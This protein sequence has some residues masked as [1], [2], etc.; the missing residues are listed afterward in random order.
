M[1]TFIPNITDIFPEPP[2]FT[3]NFGFL[4]NMLRRKQ[5]LYEQGFSQLANQYRNITRSLTNPY[6][7]KIRDEYLKQAQSSLKSISTLDLSQ[8]QNVENASKIFEPFYKNKSVLADMALTAH[9][10]QQES[11][12]E[13]YR[14]REGGKEYSDD[15]INLVRLQ[16]AKFAKDNPSNYGMYLNSKEYYTPYYNYSDEYLKAIEKFKPSSIVTEKLDGFYKI[17]TTDKSWYQQELNEYLDKVLSDKAKNQMRI[18]STVRLGSL[19]TEQ[20]GRIYSDNLKPTVKTI[21]QKVED[22]ELYTRKEKDPSKLRDYTSSLEYYKNKLTELNSIINAV[23]SNDFSYIE[24]NK[25]K[26]AFDLYYHQKIKDMS[27]AFAHKDIEVD[28]DT[29]TVALEMWKEQQANWR[30]LLT[31]KREREKEGKKEEEKGVPVRVPGVEVENL[32]KIESDIETAQSYLEATKDYLKS[33]ISNTIYMGKK[34]ASEINE[35]DFKRFLELKTIIDPNTGVRTI[36]DDV[37]PSEKKLLFNFLNAGAN[38]STQQKKKTTIDAD[39]E[40]Y[41]RSVLGEKDYN[42]AKEYYSRS[43]DISDKS[44]LK[45]PTINPLGYSND[46]TYVKNKVE[47]KIKIDTFDDF[48]KS[49]GYTSKELRNVLDS[50]VKNINN[51]KSNPKFYN[52][53]INRVGIALTEKSKGYQNIITVLGSAGID[54]KKITGVT[55][56]NTA[57]GGDVMIGLQTEGKESID[58][59]TAKEKLTSLGYNDISI[60]GNKLYIKG[61][62]SKMNPGASN[63]YSIVHPNHVTAVEYLETSFVTPGTNRTAEITFADRENNPYV[64]NIKKSGGVGADDA[65]YYLT[66]PNGRPLTDGPYPNIIEA[67]TMAAKIF[68]LPKDQILTLYSNK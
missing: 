39:A 41:A 2:L 12:A 60:L 9:W 36:K 15:N 47:E 61:A 25:Q 55:K 28:I 8:N 13:S 34:P 45:K 5:A 37:S 40:V 50:Y 53:S 31:D 20:L 54:S 17:K 23:E 57:S 29:N 30:A 21:Q 68:N 16:K 56:I 59:I 32:S 33:H 3:P 14:L 44:R 52:T 64:I 46:N 49:K 19:P 4:D 62:Y 26:L 1:A 65:M 42:I 48:A 11:I 51:F 22:L 66:L 24:N 10:E 35:N 6:N 27:S 43:S 63:P 7:S 67:Y 18:E 58:P 38:L